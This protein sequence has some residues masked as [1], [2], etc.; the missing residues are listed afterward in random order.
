MFQGNR[1]RSMLSISDISKRLC[2]YL[3]KKKG[4]GWFWLSNKVKRTRLVL[5]ENEENFISKL[6]KKQNWSFI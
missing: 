6:G 4:L 5:S 2:Y 3:P 1:L